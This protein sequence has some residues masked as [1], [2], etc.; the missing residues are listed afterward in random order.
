MDKKMMDECDDR[1]AL[2]PANEKSKGQKQTKRGKF[3]QEMPFPMA[4][5]RPY[6]EQG[7]GGNK[8]KVIKEAK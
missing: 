1:E 8:A 3:A 7:H 2:H 5:E 6:V 4:A